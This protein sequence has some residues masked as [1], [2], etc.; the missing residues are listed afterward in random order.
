MT[1]DEVRDLLREKLKG[2]TQ[3]DLAHDLGISPAY[4]CDVLGGFRNPGVKL[5]R[6]LGLSKSVDYLPVKRNGRKK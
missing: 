1:A 5:L 3:N 6:A 4:L 2:G